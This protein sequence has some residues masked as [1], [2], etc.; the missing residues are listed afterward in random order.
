MKTKL[1]CWEDPVV[2]SVA[3]DKNK[4]GYPEGTLV[5]T[6]CDE[7]VSYGNKVEEVFEGVK[8]C[9]K[10]DH[11]SQYFFNETTFSMVHLLVC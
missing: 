9:P 8:E 10:C 2:H 6:N 7:F 11:M 1:F 3:C 5:V 4:A